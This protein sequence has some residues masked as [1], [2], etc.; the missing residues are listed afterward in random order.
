MDLFSMMKVTTNAVA[1]FVTKSLLK[2]ITSLK[3]IGRFY[4][5]LIY[6]A[7]L[8]SS[9]SLRNMHLGPGVISSFPGLNWK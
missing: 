5:S 9:A 2:G 3:L 6:K 7:E 1:E 4:Q 8:P